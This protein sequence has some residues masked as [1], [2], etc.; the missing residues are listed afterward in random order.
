MKHFSDH[1]NNLSGFMRLMLAIVSG[2]VY[3]KNRSDYS[4]KEER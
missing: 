1:C 2:C 4:R 3:D